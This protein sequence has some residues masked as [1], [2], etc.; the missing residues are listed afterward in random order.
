MAEFYVNH[1]LNDS[2]AVKFNISLRYFV[3]KGAEGEHVWTLEIGTTHLDANGDAIPTQ[4]VHSISAEDLDEVIET[5]VA[6]MCAVIDWSPLVEDRR[7]PYVSDAYPGNAT[8]VP[9]GFSAT[10]D[11]ADNLPSA[12]I[13]L[14]NMKVTLNTGSTNFDITAEVT[15]N[16]DPYEYELRWVPLARVYDTYD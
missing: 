2:K 14:S 6:A 7:A 5:A 12:G 9:I 15:T 11:L 16:G 1:S 4:R 3:I 13:D 8:N 10:I